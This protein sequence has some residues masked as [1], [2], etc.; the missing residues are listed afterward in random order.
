M[1]I[2]EAEERKLD[3][4]GRM[5]EFNELFQKLQD[6]GAL[7]EISDK[8]LMEWSGPVHYVSLQHVINEESSTTN[9]RIVSISSLT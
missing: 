2:A 3:R 6:L 5:N 8:E 7:E 1:K 9:F 4:E